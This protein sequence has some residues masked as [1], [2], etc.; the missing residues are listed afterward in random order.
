MGVEAARRGIVNDAFVLV[1]NE[2]CQAVVPVRIVED[3][4]I[5]GSAGIDEPPAS[6][7][8]SL[9]KMGPGTTVLGLDQKR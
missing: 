9:Q 1:P 2:A 8:Q 7:D 6:I 4:G 3:R 5:G